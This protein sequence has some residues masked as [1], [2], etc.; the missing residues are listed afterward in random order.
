M[1]TNVALPLTQAV[2][3][4][5]DGF[6]SADLQ[7]FV[8]RAIHAAVKRQI[9]HPPPGQQAGLLLPVLKDLRR[10]LL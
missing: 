2:A 8:D 7:A 10:P 4:K 9:S 3:A 5:A 6:D 1:S